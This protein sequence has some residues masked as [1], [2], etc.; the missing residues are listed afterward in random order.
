[1]LPGACNARRLDPSQAA[2]DT[3]ANGKAASSCCTVF[4]PLVRN[5]TKNLGTRTTSLCEPL[6]RRQD[7]Q[8][9]SRT[10]ARFSEAGGALGGR[11]RLSTGGSFSFVGKRA[12]NRARG[13]LTALSA[14]IESRSS[15]PKGCAFC[16]VCTQAREGSKQRRSEPTNGGPGVPGRTASHRRPQPAIGG[17]PRPSP[18]CGEPWQEKLRLTRETGENQSP[19]RTPAA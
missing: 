8:T 4:A 13:R 7:E 3:T 12:A 17:T 18:D 9:A 5:P 11:A 6:P 16:V 14:G 10:I 2:E 19:Y 1:L 15:S